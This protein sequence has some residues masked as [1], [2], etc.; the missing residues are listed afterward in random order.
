MSTVYD[1]T[2]T[3]S[4]CGMERVYTSCSYFAFGPPDL[5]Q[6]PPEMGRST[7]KYWVHR[8]PYCGYVA[9]DVSDSCP[10]NW[11]FFRTAAYRTCNW[12]FF[13]SP[14]AKKFYRQYLIAMQA[15]YDADAYYA[16][17]HAAWACDD[18]HDLRNAK[19]C[20]EL[21]VQQINKQ[22][23]HEDDSDESTEGLLLIKADLLRRSRHFSEV[24]RE[25]RKIRFSNEQM[26]A[27]RVF[28]IKMARRKNS[29]CYTT[30]DALEFQNTAVSG[31][32]IV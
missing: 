8:C 24:V 10:V 11:R 15:G 6:R 1:E 28:E 19:Y 14:L 16:A 21:A 25:Y 32:Q 26:N 22:L 5:D 2:L 12:R 3:C 27:I 18:A 7:M 31:D 30:E 23:Q 9:G 29:K 4:V 13:L 20:R 17:L